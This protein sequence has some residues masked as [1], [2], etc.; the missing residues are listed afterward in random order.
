MR[1][2][3]PSLFR[4]KGL[5]TYGHNRIRH[6]FLLNYDWFVSSF[7]SRISR[8]RW[9][10]NEQQPFDVRL[11]ASVE[12]FEVARPILR[13]SEFEKTRRIN[14]VDL[15][16][17]NDS[18]SLWEEHWVPVLLRELPVD[19]LAL[20]PLCPFSSFLNLI[21]NGSVFTGWKATRYEVE[22]VRGGE[23]V[24]KTG[25]SRALTAWEKDSLSRCV[26]SVEALIFFLSEDSRVPG[27]WRKVQWQREVGGEGWKRLELDAAVVESH[28]WAPDAITVV[29]RL[30]LS[31]CDEADTIG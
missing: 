11:A 8:L 28:K 6:V 7:P 15:K 24:K 3:V 1:S 18:M 9:L 2:F 13:S 23:E 26:S 16:K 4:V 21:F 10:F 27:A 25:G 22:E 30:P 12:M 20:T 29:V 14:P 5:L 19:A 31:V 17:Y